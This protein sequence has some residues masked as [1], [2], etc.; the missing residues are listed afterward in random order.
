MIRRQ[1]RT[2]TN[3]QYHIPKEQAC[4]DHPKTLYVDEQTGRCLV[5]SLST[6]DN[7]IGAFVLLARLPWFQYGDEERCAVA[8]EGY[9]VYL[10]Q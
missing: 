10:S 9:G 1:Q 7:H 6:D 5:V 4:H 8:L 2:S 3:V